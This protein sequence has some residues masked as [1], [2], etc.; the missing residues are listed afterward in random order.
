M[1]LPASGLIAKERRQ[2]LR[3][4]KHERDWQLKRELESR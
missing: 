1:G 4:R 3:K 2:H